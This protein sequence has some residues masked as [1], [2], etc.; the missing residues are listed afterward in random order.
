[1]L[2]DAFRIKMLASRRF[3][4]LVGWNIFVLVWGAGIFLFHP[5]YSYFN[6]DR[7][8]IVP[9]DLIVI[10]IHTTIGYHLNLAYQFLMCLACISG[11]VAID[12]FLIMIVSTFS[13]ANDLVALDCR[14]LSDTTSR[15]DQKMKLHNI[16]RQVQ[17]SNEWV[18]SA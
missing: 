2:N 7:P 3:V 4:S 8:N 18:K 12:I 13:L 14:Q 9:T 1:M 6:G 16:I 5:I 11:N 15:I 10:D 17:D